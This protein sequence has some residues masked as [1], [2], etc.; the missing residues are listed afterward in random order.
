MRKWGPD[1]RKLYRAL[2]RVDED[3]KRF[4]CCLCTICD[5]ERGWKL[6]KDALGHLKRYHLY[7]ELNVTA[8]QY[9][10]LFMEIPHGFKS[11]R[12]SSYG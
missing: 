3:D 12:C 7:S 1:E 5:D 4:Y 10:F 6:T 8:G 9:Y 11:T 2:H